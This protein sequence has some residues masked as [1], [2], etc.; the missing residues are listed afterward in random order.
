MQVAQAAAMQRL[1]LLAVAAVQPQPMLAVDVAETLQ[2]LIAVVHLLRV[3]SSVDWVIAQ[4]LLALKDVWQALAATLVTLQPLIAGAKRLSKRVAVVKLLLL[5]HVAVILHLAA[6]GFLASLDRVAIVAVMLLQLIADAKHPLRQTVVAKAAY[7][8]DCSAA[9]DHA[10]VV[11]MQL[12]VLRR[13]VAVK[14][15]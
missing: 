7:A 9:L 13:I 6:A 2:R 1:P 4:W 5:S 11:V 15:E 8:V 12:L 3:P 14:K 10:D